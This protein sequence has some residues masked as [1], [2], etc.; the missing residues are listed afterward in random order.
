M[1]DYSIMGSNPRKTSSATGSDVP[2]MPSPTSWV[3]GTDFLTAASPRVN[4]S[5]EDM[6]HG[7]SPALRLNEVEYLLNCSSPRTGLI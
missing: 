1:L 7:L 5:H 4:T 3:L 2:S 6:F